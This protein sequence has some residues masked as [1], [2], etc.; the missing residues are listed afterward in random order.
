MTVREL[1]EAELA[2]KRGRVEALGEVECRTM[3][4]KNGTSS[5]QVA[6]DE[7]RQRL[8]HM[9]QQ[10]GA[11]F[12]VFEPHLELPGRAGKDDTLILSARVYGHTLYS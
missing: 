4:H 2:R 5:I 9:A 12:I 7:A 11:H 1:T 10:K 8:L 6:S 3:F